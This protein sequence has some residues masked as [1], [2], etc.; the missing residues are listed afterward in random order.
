M[1]VD[2]LDVNATAGDLA[3]V[4]AFDTTVARTT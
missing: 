3:E 1:H 2:P 4:F